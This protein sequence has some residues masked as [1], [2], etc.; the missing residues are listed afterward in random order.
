MMIQEDSEDITK[1]TNS[2]S[3][4]NT[5]FKEENSKKKK[6]KKKVKTHQRTTLARHWC[7]PHAPG[8][9]FSAEKELVHEAHL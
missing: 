6:A 5:S 8:V 2:I 7:V 1:W 4:P 3:S 9:Q